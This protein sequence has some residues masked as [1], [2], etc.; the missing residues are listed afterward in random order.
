MSKKSR[1]LRTPN[2][3]PEAYNAPT[4]TTPAAAVRAAVDAQ[5]PAPVQPLNL[6]DEYKDVIHDLRRTFVIFATMV[7]IMLV[8]SF[9]LR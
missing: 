7:A 6:I 9:F 1:R 5:T 4:S 3:P 8:G 2:L